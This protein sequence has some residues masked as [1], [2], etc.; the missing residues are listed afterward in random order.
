M[1]FKKIQ[2]LDNY[3]LRNNIMVYIELGYYYLMKVNIF[4]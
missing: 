4:D 2:S 1:R 3:V